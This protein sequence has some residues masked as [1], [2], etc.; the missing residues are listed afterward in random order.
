[1]LFG[2]KTPPKA[3]GTAQSTD[4]AVPA[5]EANAAEPAVA[6]SPLS[7]LSNASAAAPAQAVQAQGAQALA[8][9]PPAPTSRT[10]SPE[11]FSSKGP[12]MNTTSPKPPT[13][14]PIPGASYKPTDIPRRTVDLPGVASRKPEGFGAPSAPV[15][16]LAAAPVQPV[17]PVGAP[18]ASEQRRLIVGRD[19][20]LNGEIGSCDVLVVEGTVEA[21]LR[22][23]RSIEIAE[24]G[25]FKG[26]VEIDEADIGGRFEG[27]ITVRGR[28]VVRSTGR[29]NG[30]VKYGQLSVEAGGLLNGS[31]GQYKAD[32][33]PA[34][35]AAEPAPAA[36]PA[37]DAI[38][39]D[40]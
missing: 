34:T 21:K 16:P 13:G 17:S 28:L 8:G 10:P 31:I 5:A 33:Q 22:D 26:S 25:L 37:P 2:R 18:L 30:A 1:M 19:I 15:A 38:V 23:G 40:G 14:G 11:P 7:S 12:E 4:G 24:T 35:P 29:I 20:S 6:M 3:Q 27:D 9:H 39:V 36:A 32:A